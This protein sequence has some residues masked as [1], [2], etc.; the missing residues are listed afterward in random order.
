LPY[1]VQAIDIMALF[2]VKSACLS[3]MLVI[4]VRH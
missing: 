3:S 1:F 2:R 4:D